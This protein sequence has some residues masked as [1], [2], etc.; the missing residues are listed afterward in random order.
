[1]ACHII[2]TVWGDHYQR[3]GSHDVILFAENAYSFVQLLLILMC[4]NVWPVAV[5]PK[6]EVL[7]ICYLLS[8]LFA[9]YIRKKVV[10]REHHAV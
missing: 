9:L 4:Q 2:H 8:A 1:M 6:E 7:F 5:F 10:H 3:D